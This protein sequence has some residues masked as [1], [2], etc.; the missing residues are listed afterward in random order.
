MSELFDDV[1][2]TGRESTGSTKYRSAW[3]A[4]HRAREL[5]RI[6]PP[7]GWTPDA[8]PELRGETRIV[9]NAETT[10]LDWWDTA[11]PIGWSYWLPASGRRGY[12]PMRHRP[13]GNLAPEQV[14][15]WLRSLR[16]LHI[17][18]AN[19]KFDLHQTRA[20][21]VDL[22]EQDNTF[23]DCAHY[24]ALLDDHRMRFGLDQLSKDVL[25]WD[26]DTDGLGKIPRAITS[27]VEFQLLHP[28]LVA[29]Y[30]V[31]NVEQVVRLV[32][33]FTPRI[34]EEDL[35]EVLALEQAV[36]PIVV[37]ME[38][39]GTFLDMDLLHRWETEV[40]RRIAA[41]KMLIYRA[42][43][44]EINSFDSPKDLAAL[45]KARGIVNT[46]K[47]EGGGMSFTDAVMR[48]HSAD[49]CIRA[50]REGGQL[51]DLDSKYLGKYAAAAR[52]DG[53]LRFNLHQLRAGR[54]EDDKRGTVSGRFSAAGD[55]QGGYNPQ[56][57]VA[58]EKQLERDWCPDYV[59][60]KLFV[61]GP[62]EQC[63][64]A[65]DM[66]QVEY[67]L[68]AHYANDPAINAA[69]AADP[70]ADFH[71]VVMEL[72][73]KLNPRLNRKLTKNINFAKIY[74]AQLLKF[75][76]MIGSIS[77]QLF[78]ELNGALRAAFDR[79]DWH[80]VRAIYADDRLDEARQLDEEYNRMF[81]AVAPLL[82]Q[83]KET[84]KQRGYV[85][86]LMGRRARLTDRF[87]SAL[88]RVVQ[89]GAA[90]INKRLLVELY[91]QRKALGVTMRLTVHDEVVTGLQD[92][93]M[94]DAVDK[95]L[96]TQYFDLRVRILWDTKI[97][98]NWAACK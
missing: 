12:L 41:Q 26:V 15:D 87:H 72:L 47:S 88:N 97:G 64:L 32:D 81:P 7:N 2:R 61:P 78:T 92:P 24:A 82:K 70:R 50:A 54:S 75:A 65:S 17:E 96:N 34:L 85:R 3:A 13:G 29:P 19:T 35:G 11:R 83:A 77:E 66:M 43:G 59:V 44:I 79:D 89:G 84:A 95:L 18:N 49:E 46:A 42:T 28:S 20:D 67:R 6:A 33:A 22:T 55:R 4:D 27:E 76:L 8:P 36:I 5:A 52:S 48:Q 69:Y 91:K 51:A 25:H 16:G 62:G 31:R 86:T 14:H 73:H 93:G 58:V 38:K 9:L 39:N 74:G 37:E 98:D 71:A 53:W 30:A 56:Q 21:G 40:Q 60:R 90:D 94:R 10:G 68:F 1:G 63:L 45:F 23:G 57:V 80:A